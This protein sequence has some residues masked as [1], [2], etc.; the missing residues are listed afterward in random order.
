MADGS[1]RSEINRLWS[2]ESVIFPIIIGNCRAKWEGL[3]TR[4]ESV[5]S[6]SPHA[7]SNRL[8]RFELLCGYTVQKWVKS[9]KNIAL[10]TSFVLVCK[11]AKYFLILMLQHTF[12]VDEMGTAKRQNLP[13]DRTGRLSKPRHSPQIRYFT[14]QV[15]R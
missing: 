11:I 15:R 1:G 3:V 10:P 12:S 6:V 4:I 13:Y 9:S 7:A 14:I 2:E 8:V 5:T